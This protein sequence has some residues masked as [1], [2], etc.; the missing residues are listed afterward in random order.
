MYIWYIDGEKA[1]RVLGLSAACRCLE[2]RAEVGPGERGGMERAGVREGGAA[3]AK[4]LTR[5]IQYI[6]FLEYYH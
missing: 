1:R 6:H 2:G 4:G 5:F 3:M